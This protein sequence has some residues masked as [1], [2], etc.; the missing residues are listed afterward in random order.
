VRLLSAAALIIAV[1]ACDSTPT[2]PFTAESIVGS[3]SLTTWN[4]AALPAVISG[5]GANRY[6][7]V[8]GKVAF[9]QGGTF[10]H[11]FT[12]ANVVNGVT[13]LVPG[14]QTGTYTVSADSVRMTLGVSMQPATLSGNTMTV[15][16]GDVTLKYQRQ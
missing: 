14:T 7:A 13:P 12:T 5:S 2:H 4:G 16:A 9:I 8:S 3:W 1:V 10:T 11:Q 6:E 15:V